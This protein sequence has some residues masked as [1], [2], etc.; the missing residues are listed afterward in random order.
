[1]MTRGM[2]TSNTDL[3]ET[4]QALFDELNRE[5]HFGIDVC[6]LPENAKCARYYTP[7]QDG[8]K[9]TW[10]GVLLVQSSLRKADREVGKE[11][12]RK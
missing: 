7:E 2:Y 3:W 11:S 6:A 5:F 12:V 4:P 1:M 10:G 8:L 9:Q